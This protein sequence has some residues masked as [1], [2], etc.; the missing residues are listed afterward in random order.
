MLGENRPFGAAMTFEKGDIVEVMYASP[1]LIERWLD[2]ERMA[3]P[4]NGHAAPELAAEAR[5]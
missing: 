4:M 2:G 3:P 5:R 1:R